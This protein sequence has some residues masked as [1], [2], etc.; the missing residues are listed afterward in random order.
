MD[1]TSSAFSDLKDEEVIIECF[2]CGECGYS[3]FSE[4]DL[5]QHQVSQHVFTAVF[6][7]IEDDNG[8]VDSKKLCTA[9]NNKKE[10]EKEVTVE[11][12]PKKKPREFSCVECDFSSN[13]KQTLKNHVASI[14]EG[15]VRFQC[16]E[17]DYKN[18]HKQSLK[19]HISTKH[20]ESEAKIINIGV[21]SN[22]KCKNS[23]PAKK[24][25]GKRYEEYIEYPDSEI[26]DEVKRLKMRETQTPTSVTVLA[27]CNEHNS[28]QHY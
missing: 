10:V 17:C 28:G 14:H 22:E 20:K 1:K 11:N 16:S 23:N 8:E 24:K 7:F 12:A 2:K 6:G 18:Y 25:R 5:N 19:Y 3:A 9:N 21:E 4:D 27:R 15:I 26:K 13:S